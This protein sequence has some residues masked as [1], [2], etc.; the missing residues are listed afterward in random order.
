MWVLRVYVSR[1]R[2]LHR[3]P[4]APMIVLTES[5]LFADRVVVVASLVPMCSLSLAYSEQCY[6]NAEL[7]EPSNSVN[8]FEKKIE[9]HFNFLRE[10]EW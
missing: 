1:W 4:I 3:V 8:T 7:H 10:P 6:F 9:N 2:T 5:A